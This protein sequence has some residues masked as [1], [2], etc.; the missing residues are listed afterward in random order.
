MRF[1]AQEHFEATPDAL[2][3]FVADT[4]RVNRAIGLQAV[5]FLHEP[6]ADGGSLVTGEFR[7]FGMLVARWTEHAFNF[8]RPYRYSVLREYSVGPLSRLNTG[9]ELIPDG[10][11]TNVHVFAEVI[12]R[13]LLGKMLAQYVVGQAS[14]NRLLTQCRQFAEF[15]LGRAPDAFPQLRPTRNAV[16]DRRLDEL[17]GRLYGTDADPSVVAY[18]REYLLHEP[19][20]RVGQM[21]PFELADAWELDRHTTLV[22]FLHSTTV[23]LLDMRWDVLCPNCRVSKAEYVSLTELREQAHCETCNITFDTNFDRLVEV[24]FKVSPSVRDA[25]S[26]TFCVGGPQNR[27]HIVAQ[28]ELGPGESVVWTAPSERG[29]FRLRSQQSARA[30][31]IEIVEDGGE[32]NPGPLHIGPDA[33]LPA[34]LCVPAVVGRIHVVNDLPSTAIAELEEQ[35]WANTAATAALVS[36]LQEFRDLCSAEVLAPGLQIGVE[37]LSLLFTDVAGSTE[38]YERLGQAR[39]FRLVQDHF[40]LVERAV[41][42]NR[43]AIVKTIGD[44]VMAVFPV[45]TDALR[46]AIAMQRSMRELAGREGVDPARLLKVGIHSGPCL[47]VT[48]NDRLDYFGTTVNTAARTEHEARG[49]EIVVT[50]DVRIEPGVSEVLKEE[51]VSE[52]TTEVA[53]RG[54][55]EPVRLFRIASPTGWTE[56][57]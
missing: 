46:A 38:L 29:M 51:A 44:A 54:L 41:R 28:A 25:G 57:S 19:D 35:G 45:G 49:G 36:T 12:P 30:A 8:E 22:T 53:L 50:Q 56:G 7:K 6:R 13:N 14:T 21:R 31:L 2:W 1:D 26:G 47:A 3:P 33:V 48:L 23:G 15:L 5:T 55:A 27:P 11:G 24:R 20:D 42:E 52:Q 10:R 34:T 40:V 39:A 9:V 43:G 37:R 4:S 18:L 17:T 16:D 32:A